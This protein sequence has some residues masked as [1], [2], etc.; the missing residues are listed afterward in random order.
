[1]V[2]WHL[3]K[4]DRTFISRLGNGEIVNLALSG[5]QEFYSCIFADNSI[6]VC[7]FDNNKA[8][9]SAANLKIGEAPILQ[10]SS[11]GDQIAFVRD[12]MVQFK[13]ILG[14]SSSVT[15]VLETNPRN[16]ATSSSQ[17][18]ECKNKMKIKSVDFCPDQ[19]YSVTIETLEDK[20]FENKYIYISSLKIWGKDKQLV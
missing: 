12:S 2:Q 11:G 3:E 1:M 10:V 5:E 6:K 9:V 17:S 8:V 15:E 13:S 16:F 19:S 20:T 14:T 7:R 18:G 4:Q